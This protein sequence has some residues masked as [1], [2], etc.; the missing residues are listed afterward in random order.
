MRELL[1][2]A[3]HARGANPQVVKDGLQVSM[4]SG[5]MKRAAVLDVDALVASLPDGDPR[6]RANNA[7]RGVVAVLNEP[8]RSTADQL[9]FMDVT[10]SIAP[11]AEG[12]GFTEGVLAAGG[13]QPFFRPYVGDMQQAYYI[14]LDDGQRLLTQ[15][16]ADRWGVHPERIDKAGL[17][18]LFHRSGRERWENNLIDGV[19]VRRLVI[20]DGGDAARG[21]LLEMYD[22]HKAQSGRFF[23]MPSSEMLVFTD[24][25]A[26]DT[27]VVFRRVVEGAYAKSDQPLST[28]VFRCIGG[29][30][31]RE[32]VAPCCNAHREL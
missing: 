10:A 13:S 31:E 29:K 11:V 16:Q 23:A 1:I 3:L 8:G 17:S 24:N 5:L 7:A 30:L 4:R 26:H 18:I 25:L 19:L 2:E 28:D 14:D 15:E 27:L 12:P 6:A 22:Y 21:T 32:P 9:T 20:G